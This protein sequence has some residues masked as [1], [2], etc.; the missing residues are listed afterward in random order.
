MTQAAQAETMGREL[1]KLRVARVGMG[2][3]FEEGRGGRNMPKK[4]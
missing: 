3:C 4:T 1:G 2:K